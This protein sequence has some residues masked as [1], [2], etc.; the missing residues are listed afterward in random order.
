MKLFFICLLSA[1][2]FS[3]TSTTST[4]RDLVGQAVAQKNVLLQ[5]DFNPE[6]QAGLAKVAFKVA[7][8]AW[9]SDCK[10]Y[11]YMVL[12]VVTDVIG[13]QMMVSSKRK[14]L[15]LEKL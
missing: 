14:E 1:L 2:L 11:A 13:D 5:S 6:P 15:I 3:F 7:K 9:K 4:E 12:D 8:K 10:L